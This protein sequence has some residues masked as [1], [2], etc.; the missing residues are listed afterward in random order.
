MSSC[1]PNRTMFSFAISLARITL[2]ASASRLSG[3]KY[4]ILFFAFLT[5]SLYSCTEDSPPSAGS[6]ISLH[7]IVITGESGYLSIP[8]ICQFTS[9]FSARIRRIVSSVVSDHSDGTHLNVIPLASR[10]CQAAK[11]ASA[12]F[13]IASSGS[14]ASSSCPLSGS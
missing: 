4:Q 7:R 11:K 13:L 14:P 3:S 10:S 12:R 2:S 5:I 6:V 1:P 8:S 9:F